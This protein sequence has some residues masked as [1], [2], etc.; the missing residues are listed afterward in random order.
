M[1]R[2]DAAGLTPWS[3]VTHIEASHSDAGT[4]YAAV[5]RHRWRITART[6]TAREFRE[7]VAS[8]SMGYPREVF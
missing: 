6:C 3:K 8:V 1:E 7:D 4:A 2:C 5:D